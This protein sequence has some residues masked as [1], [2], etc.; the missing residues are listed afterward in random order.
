MTSDI[1]IKMI[2]FFEKKLKSKD[3]QFLNIFG[4]IKQ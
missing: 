3:Q 1:L 4:F 2:L